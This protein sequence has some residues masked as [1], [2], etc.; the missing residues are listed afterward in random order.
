MDAT[1]QSAAR[2]ARRLVARA[3]RPAVTAGPV[4]VP[5]PVAQPAGGLVPGGVER[6]P[7]GTGTG[8]LPAPEPAES[9]HPAATIPRRGIE[10][11]ALTAAAT[12]ELGE[13]ARPRPATPG[14]GPAAPNLGLAAPR[15][16]RAWAAP[17]S[18]SEHEPEKDPGLT[19]GPLTSKRGLTTR[20]P[21][22]G[23]G[24]P[25]RL[26]RRMAI[27]GGTPAREPALSDSAGST[28]SAASAGSA[29]PARPAAQGAL[30]A[31]KPHEAQADQAVQVPRPSSAARRS[32]R[33][34]APEDERS[35]QRRGAAAPSSV[36][37]HRIEVVTP[38]PAVPP[39][40][41]LASLAD[42]RRG[43][44]RRAGGS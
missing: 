5:I 33:S 2:G 19:I 13:G 14:P 15:S 30:A 20:Q 28:G 25:E 10:A 17:S 21:E 44:S 7:D 1:A 24:G 34:H 18:A 43:A 27:A 11:T 32:A 29:D 12:I 36:V 41:P 22:T 9:P 31:P 40:D 3:G 37:I 23:E 16:A 26:P 42:V 35:G 8:A 6:T 4:W 39:P 38:P